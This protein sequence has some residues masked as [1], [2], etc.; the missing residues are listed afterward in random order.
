MNQK[1]TSLL[2]YDDAGTGRPV[3]LIHGFPLCRKMWRPQVPALVAAGFRVITPDLRGYGD[4]PPDPIPS[5]MESY[6]DDLMDLLDELEIEQAVF[7]GMSMGGYVLLNLLERYP[8]RIGAA[9][10]LVTRAAEDDPAAKERRQLLADETLSNGQ[11]KVTDTFEGILFGSDTAQT[12]PELVS[13]VRQWMLATPAEGMAAGLLAMR[14]RKDS[15][16]QLVSFKLPALVIGAAQ[17]KAVPL[18]HSKVLAQGLSQ[19]TLKVIE[20][21]GHMVNLEKPEIFNRCL[22][23]FLQ[24]L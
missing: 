3:V 6:A 17:D 23:E 16:N 24:S 11:R 12:R 14:S 9:M 8:Q 13:E 20:G 22:L 19:A 18:E 5:G 21:A 4:T 10:F 7:G 15:I 1:K 2:A